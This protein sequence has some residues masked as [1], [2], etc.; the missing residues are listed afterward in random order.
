MTTQAFEQMAAPG[1]GMVIGA[2]E[3]VAAKIVRV[4]EL[5][6]IERFLLHVSVGTLAHAQVLHAIELFG[7]KVAPLVRGT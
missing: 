5:L 1:G 2:P 3:E 6:G 4:R 7:T